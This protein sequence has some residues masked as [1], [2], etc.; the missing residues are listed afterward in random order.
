M[1][2]ASFYLVIYIFV[3]VAV[4]IL[5]HRGSAISQKKKVLRSA[6]QYLGIV[7]FLYVLCTIFSDINLLLVTLITFTALLGCSCIY[8]KKIL[9]IRPFELKQEREE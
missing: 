1:I 7:G 6:P 3:H 5:R 9:R 8:C 2:G 4:L